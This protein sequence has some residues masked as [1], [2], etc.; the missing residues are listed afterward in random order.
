MV[1]FLGLYGIATMKDA[2]VAVNLEFLGGS[3][4]WNMSFVRAAHD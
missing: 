2:F 4:H 3:N 1:A